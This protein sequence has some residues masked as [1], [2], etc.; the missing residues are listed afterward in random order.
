MTYG[1]RLLLNQTTSEKNMAIAEHVCILKEIHLIWNGFMDFLGFIFQLQFDGTK[2][3][4][5]R[6]IERLKRILVDYLKWCSNF[7]DVIAQVV[8]TIQKIHHVK[9]STLGGPKCH[10]C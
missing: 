2:K 1:S 5:V 6:L 3:E 9:R 7:F 8:N 4:S 10:F